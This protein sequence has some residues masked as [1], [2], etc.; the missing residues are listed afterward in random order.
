MRLT[1]PSLH[2]HYDFKT[3]IRVTFPLRNLIHSQHQVYS[4][5]T[6]L[7][8]Q[9]SAR[10]DICWERR[11]QATTEADSLQ[12]ELSPSLQKVMDLASKPSS[13]NWLTSLP[14][15]NTAFTI[16]RVPLWMCSNFPQRDS[17]WFL[18][19]VRLCTFLCL[20]NCIFR[21]QSHFRCICCFCVSFWV[22]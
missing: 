4:I 7:D 15:R 1:L 2:A 5:C 16:I 6:G 13:S 10:A 20:P 17:H 21:H 12:D 19:V 3:S 14:L 22:L 11:L 9:L 18:K 8:G